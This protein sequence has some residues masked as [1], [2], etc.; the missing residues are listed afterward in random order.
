MPKGPIIALNLSGRRNE[1]VHLEWWREPLKDASSAIA[2]AG[3]LGAGKTW[4]IMYMLFHLV[5]IG[6]QFLAID[7]TDSG[8]YARPA[9]TAGPPRHRRLD[10]TA[11][12]DG[13]AAHIPRRHRRRRRSRTTDP[14][15]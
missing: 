3:E 10:A 13:S 7:R 9:A 12:V 14:A 1:P 11:V 2:I 8:E 4:L 15:V 6:G 5:D